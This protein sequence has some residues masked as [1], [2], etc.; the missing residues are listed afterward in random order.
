MRKG[1]PKLQDMVE[2]HRASSDKRERAASVS[3]PVGVECQ[4]NLGAPLLRDEKGR[5]EWIEHELDMC[6]QVLDPPLPQDKQS[7]PVLPFMAPQPVKQ[8]MTEF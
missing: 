1:C 7:S 8:R 5:R 4:P 6:C 2:V 3:R